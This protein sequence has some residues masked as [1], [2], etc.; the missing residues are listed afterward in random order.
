MPEAEALRLV[1]PKQDAAQRGASVAFRLDGSF[2]TALFKVESTAPSHV[3]PGLPTGSSQWGLWDWDVV[4]L[5]VSCAGHPGRLPYYEFQV[6]PLGQFLELEILEP[7]R[8]VNRDFASGFGHSARRVDEGRWEAEMRLPLEK[9]G[10]D[11]DPASIHG[12]AFA[13]LGEPPART[14]WSLFLA[15]QEKPDFHLPGKFRPL[16]GRV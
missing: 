1:H 10:W 5:F 15:P 2:L 16:F 11:G 7:R 4:E 9:L 13:I 6:S 12:N 3:N 8:R 14:Y